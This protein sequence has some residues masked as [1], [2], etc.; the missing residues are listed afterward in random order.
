M[1]IG[2]GIRK[3]RIIRNYTQKQLADKVGISISHLSNIERGL[4]NT[5]F[6]TIIEIAK[7][8]DMPLIYLIVLSET[9]EEHKQYYPT[10]LRTLLVLHALM[11]SK[12]VYA[13][14]KK[15]AK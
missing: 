8:L 6:S 14:K 2:A 10:D 4:R 5:S 7:Q 1:D 13:I 11:K 3:I 12:A 9:K 15:G